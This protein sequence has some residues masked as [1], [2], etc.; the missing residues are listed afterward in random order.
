MHRD[1]LVHARL[2]H[3]F[4]FFADAANLERLTPSWLRFSIRTPMPVVMRA[5]LEIEYRIRLYGLPIPWVSV[6]EA[7]EPG[8]MFIDRQL[9]GPYLWWRHQ[10]RF[11][12]VGEST[13]VIDDVEYRPR[14][15]WMTGRIVRRDVERIFEYRQAELQRIFRVPTAT[16]HT[17]GR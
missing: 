11:E 13:R 5:G 12:A 7:W 15:A 8:L 14:V 1:T 2:P 16:V 10:H 3:V 9:T 4:D 6:I 17:E